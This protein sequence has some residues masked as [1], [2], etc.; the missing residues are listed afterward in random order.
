[1]N[2]IR[3]DLDE[4]PRLLRRIRIAIDDVGRCDVPGDLVRRMNEMLHLGSEPDEG[5]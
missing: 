5:R 2:S 4:T 1:M 3:D